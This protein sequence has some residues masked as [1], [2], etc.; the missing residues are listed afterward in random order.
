[1][2]IDW[3]DFTFASR[4]LPFPQLTF[5]IELSRTFHVCPTHPHPV[6][7]R[8]KKRARCN[9]AGTFASSQ[10]APSP[11]W[12]LTL[13]IMSFLTGEQNL[14]EIIRRMWP[15]GRLSRSSRDNWIWFAMAALAP[16][17]GNRDPGSDIGR[18]DIAE[19]DTVERYST[20]GVPAHICPGG[21]PNTTW[22]DF[23]TQKV[24]MHN[25]FAKKLPISPKSFACQHIRYSKNCKTSK[26]QK[27]TKTSL[28]WHRWL[29]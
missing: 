25:C 27:R 20:G 10:R 2:F 6:L 9:I 19:S 24:K 22:S 12:P 21:K 4:R 3:L 1:M 7:W 14:A 8:L 16:A 18:G 28:Q 23:N 17:A 11:S 5:K 15:S 13:S 26:Y 29:S